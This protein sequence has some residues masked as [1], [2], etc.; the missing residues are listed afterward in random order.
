MGG[1]LKSEISEIL[2]QHQWLKEE[3]DNCINDNNIKKIGNE[4]MKW[5]RYLRN[6]CP[7]K[8]ASLLILFGH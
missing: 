5:S 2:K 7:S 6:L 3:K 4:C 8:P 1:V